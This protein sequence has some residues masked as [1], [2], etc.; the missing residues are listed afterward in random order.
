M[1]LASVSFPF[2]YLIYF[3]L[4]CNGLVYQATVYQTFVFSGERGSVVVKET[5]P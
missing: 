5:A 2:L 1:E 3:S 4:Q